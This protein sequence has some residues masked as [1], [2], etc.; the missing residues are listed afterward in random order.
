MQRI[1]WH[2]RKIRKG[3]FIKMKSMMKITGVLSVFFWINFVLG[4]QKTVIL[5]CYSPWR[6]YAVVRPI[7]F[8]GDSLADDPASYEFLK[9]HSPLP[10]TN[11]YEPA[12]DVSEWQRNP[13]PF[14][15]SFNP[16]PNYRERHAYG[17][18]GIPVG[19]A[20]LYVRGNFTVTEPSSVKELI[21]S[22]SF[23]GGLIVYLNGKEAGRAF[24]PNG[25]IE[26]YTLASD[27]PLE[28]SL[29][30]DGQ[31]LHFTSDYNGFREHYQ[32]R[33]REV[34]LRLPGEF[35]LPGTNVLA[36]EFHRTALPAELKKKSAEC[37]A[38][39][40]IQS[41]E[42]N[43]L[44]SGG[45]IPNVERPSGIQ[46][47]NANPL[48]TFPGLV[49]GDP[50]ES[51]KPVH[52]VGTRN[53][54][55]T[56]QVIMSSDQPIRGLRV[57]MSELRHQD[58]KSIIADE[59]L[60]VLYGN[61]NI[62][63][64]PI[65]VPAKK[66]YRY[67]TRKPQALQPIGLT[68]HVPVDVSS[69]VYKGD[70]HITAEGFVTNVP[71]HLK[72]C[73]W[74]LPDPW[75]FQTIVD[76]VQSPESVALY[77]EVPLWS[78][79]HFELLD[80]SIKFLSQIGSRV[81]YIPLLTKTHFGNEQSMVHWIPQPD[82]TYT[83]DFSIVERYIDLFLKNKVK[84]LAV[85]LEIKTEYC[86]NDDGRGAEGNVCVTR[87]NPTT[88]QPEEMEG[89]P[90]RDTETAV[91]FWKPVADGIVKIL[92]KRGLTDRLMLGIFH[93]SERSGISAV[94]AVWNQIFPQAPLFSHR[95]GYARIRFGGKIVGF[96]ADCYMV[97]YAPDPDNGYTYGWR[98]D[99]L[100]VQFARNIQSVPAYRLI[101]EW[102]IQGNRRGFGRLGL[103]F[104]HVL[105]DR[106][107]QKRITIV[108]R[109]G[110][111]R[112]ANLTIGSYAPQ[113][114]LTPGP[115]GAI[116]SH[117]FEMLREGIQ[118]CE[119]RIFI[120]QIL[121]DNNSR[122]KLGEAFA[123]ECQKIL[124]ER[125]RCNNWA[126]GSDYAGSPLPGGYLGLGWFV[127]SG[128][129]SRSEKLFNSAGKIIRILGRTE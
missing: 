20:L 27:Y 39:V 42:L 44:C 117:A 21:L 15:S 121:I 125:I 10:P 45:I 26:P 17:V 101:S 53:G 111:N 95:H 112:L 89:P 30:P 67:E 103:D 126:G 68:V 115:D 98:H 128:W 66:L 37:W 19:L 32:K 127:F 107:G 70:V 77:Y 96:Q 92:E 63:E 3:Q 94:V 49:F 74:T 57:S 75:D 93:D 73:D 129:Q 6:G 25:K 90:Y 58:G 80:K 99:W 2:D 113:A 43:A 86:A 48:E 55:F 13:I 38:T 14:Y 124:D 71:L 122:A 47:W 118:E 11:W 119:A 18:G 22:A 12:F 8:K 28:A 1:M 40:G 105:K 84:P 114:C 52:L 76:M 79:K 33:L 123:E 83:Y 46:I 50:H 5:D 35:L 64:T 88:Q 16:G 116:S 97:K 120:E 4:E 24:M 36:V 78:D 31:S 9:E 110:L 106:Q 108:N 60:K 82:G 81:I 59:H 100:A 56:G 51:L 65:E 85:C 91:K 23:R 104:W 61:T 72:V 62:T 54:W 87:R 109:H 69:G 34:S 102:N 29:K 41:I 7:F